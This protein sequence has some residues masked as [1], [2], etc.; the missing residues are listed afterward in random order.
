[1]RFFFLS[2]FFL[3]CYGGYAQEVKT[4][5]I[6]G[7]TLEVE[8]K[9]LLAG[10]GIYV[11][12]M[13]VYAPT[14]SKY[15]FSSQIGMGLTYKRISIGVFHSLFQG[16]LRTIVVFPNKFD[17]L[18]AHGGGYAGYELIKRKHLEAGLRVHYSQGDM[19]WEYA[20]S[21]EDFLRDKFQVVRPEVTISLVPLRYVKIFTALGYNKF[22]D[23]DL[24]SATSDDFSGL[25][26]GLGIKIGYFS[27]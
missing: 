20:E 4:D 19:V 1:M 9:S 27:E 21:K 12:G 16:D 25:T 7:D 10:A 24:P 13:A 15:N 8:K 2:L 22:M 6:P 18:Y 3:L 17:L 14:P 23:L 26:L 5:T 11:E